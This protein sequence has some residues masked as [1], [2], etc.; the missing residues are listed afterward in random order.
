MANGLFNYNFYCGI[1][2]HRKFLCELRIQERTHDIDIGNAF[3]K[4]TIGLIG[5]VNSYRVIE[6]IRQRITEWQFPVTMV[7]DQHDY[8]GSFII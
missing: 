2:Q 1:I 3:I 4:L 8:R 5:Q 6:F 7:G